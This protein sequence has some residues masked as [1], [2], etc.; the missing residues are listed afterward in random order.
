MSLWGN[1]DLVGNGGSIGI[2]L[3]TK[4]ISGAGTTF[5]TA[6]F[7]VSPGDVI[8]VGTGATY[9]RAVIA[10]VT[11]NTNASVATTQYLIPDS[12]GNIPTGTS[13]FVSELPVSSLE[14]QNYQAPDAKSNRTSSVF[15]VDV[16]EQVA[17]NAASGDA[18]KYAPAHTGWVGVTTYMDAHNNLRVKTE[19]LVAG[20]ISSSTDY[21]AQDDAKF[22]E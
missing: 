10:T 20:G 13:Y 6:G 7:V 15:G 19:V 22:P 12:D 18:R 4:A 17:A 1:K 11:D 14:D 8:V 3:S 2:N 5:A 9:G 21:D 16:S